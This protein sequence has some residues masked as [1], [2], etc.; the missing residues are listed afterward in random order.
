M[1]RVRVVQAFFPERKPPAGGGFRRF[2]RTPWVEQTSHFAKSA[3]GRGKK[4]D[5]KSSLDSRLREPHAAAT[6]QRASASRLPPHPACS[7][8]RAARPAHSAVA[9]P[10]AAVR[11]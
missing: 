4:S 1:Y 5:Y 6:A 8:G 3:L 11:A 7:A 9:Q 2:A 10:K